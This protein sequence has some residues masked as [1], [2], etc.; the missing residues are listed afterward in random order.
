MPPN[1][2]QPTAN[3]GTPSKLDPTIVNLA[4]AIRDVE[5]KGNFSA[6]GK[7]GEY[8]AYQFTQPTWDSIAPRVL[9][10]SVPYNQADELE[11]NAVAYHYIKELKEKG[12]NAGQIASIWN[13]GKPDPNVTGTG[14]NDFGVDYDV[15]GYVNNV[16]AKYLEYKG[17]DT[18][19][20]TALP[21]YGAFFPASPD[22]SPI[23]AGFKALGNLPSAVY[24][25]GAALV[26][27][28]A[29][30][31]QTI[32]GIS[33]AGVGAYQAATGDKDK[34]DIETQ[35]F[36]AF[37]DALKQRYGSLEA[38]QNTATNDPFGFG[39]D[40]AGILAG[41]ASLAGRGAEAAQLASR[42]AQTVT[43]PV[44]RAVE[45]V[46]G[47]PFRLLGRTD[48]EA[49]GA[50]E[51]TGIRLPAGAYTSSPLVQ[52]AET[53]ALAGVGNERMVARIS[54]V[55]DQMDAL[56]RT[57]VES[58]KGADD[59]AEAGQAI[60]KGLEK[61]DAAFRKT[62]ST[63][64]DEVQK[65]AGDLAA[66]TNNTIR[67][68]DDIISRKEAIADTGN[69]KFFKDKLAVATGGKGDVEFVPV[70]VRGKATVKASAKQYDPPKFST[71]KEMRTNIGELIDTRFL[72]PFVKQHYG[73][74]KQLYGALTQDIRSTIQTTRNKELLRLYD[75]ANAKYVAGRRIITSQ[76][77]RNIARLAEQ[78]KYSNI[79]DSLVKPSMAI[80]DI[81]R[82]MAVIG[83]QGANNLRAG[84]IK[85][86]IEGARN[87]EGEFTAQGI[88]RQIKKYG[89][90]KVGAILTP[91]QF[92]GLRDLGK[93]TA[94]LD[95]VS[96]QFKGSQTAFILKNLAELGSVGSGVISILTG[97]FVL[98]MKLIG[99]VIGTEA[100]SYL[101]ASNLGQKVLLWGATRGTEFA[102]TARTMGI[103]PPPDEGTMGGY[104][105]TGTP[106]D[107]LPGGGVP[108]RGGGSPSSPGTPEGVPGV[109]SQARRTRQ[110]VGD[111]GIATIGGSRNASGTDTRTSQI[112][113]TGGGL[114]DGTAPL[115]SEFRAGTLMGRIRES[116]QNY[117]ENVRPGLVVEDITKGNQQFN[118]GL[119]S[120][121]GRIAGAMDDLVSE[122]DELVKAG[123]FEEA[124]RK[125]NDALAAGTNVLSQAFEG[126]GI[127][128]KPRGVGIGIYGKSVE[129][130]YDAV[131]VVP[132]GKED[133][134]HY[135]LADVAD[136]RF[137]QYSML[138]YR[139]APPD[140]KYGIVDEV[141]GISY[142]PHLRFNLE[143]PLTAK[144]VSEITDAAEK[145][146]IGG[147]SLR[148]GGKSID[149]IKLTKY[150]D[151]Y[152]GFLNNLDAFLASA[153]AKGIS[154][155]T[156]L[157]TAEARFVGSNPAEGHGFSSYA[158]V[159][160]AFRE[161]NPG[162]FNPEGSEVT[163]KVIERLRN[164]ESVSRQ[165]VEQ[166]VRQQDISPMERGVVLDALSDAEQGGMKKVPTK[167]LVA[168]I[169]GKSLPISMYETDSYATYGLREV[170]LGTKY[171]DDGANNAKTLVFETP[172]EHG[173]QG[174][175]NNPKHFGHTR[176]YID[177]VVDESQP[178]RKATELYEVRKVGEGKDA[179]WGIFDKKKPESAGAINPDSYKTKAAA[180]KALDEMPDARPTKKVGY[181]TELQSD[182]FQKANLET[183][184]VG[185]DKIAQAKKDAL[186][187]SGWNVREAAARKKY[188]GTD[189]PNAS[190]P[191]NEEY[192]AEMQALQRER[193]AILEDAEK[194]A[195]EGGLNPM[196][197]QLINQSKNDRYVDT[198]LRGTLQWMEKQ[199]VEEVRVATPS[200]VA[201]IEG[202][203]NSDDLAPYRLANGDRVTP[204][205]PDLDFGD[206]IE[207]LGEDYTVVSRYQGRNASGANEGEIIIAPKD[208]VRSFRLSDHIEE[209][210]S[211]QWDE[212]VVYDLKERK[213][214]RKVI[215]DE[216]D[217][218]D[219]TEAQAQKLLDSEDN[220]DMG[221][222]YLEK[223]A[224]GFSH[225]DAKE[226]LLSTF[227]EWAGDVEDLFGRGKV[228]YEDISA[229][230]G[231]DY[232]VWVV[233]DDVNVESLAQPNTYSGGLDETEITTI[234]PVPGR[235]QG[236][237]NH[238]ATEARRN[239][240]ENFGET[241]AGVLNGYVE[242]F[243]RNLQKLSREQNVPIKYVEDSHGSN[244]WYEFPLTK[245]KRYLF[246]S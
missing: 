21:T 63:L 145:A 39:A 188:E 163:S 132:R 201:K 101:F 221:R 61:F 130:N 228:Y 243:S 244:T 53:L 198:L 17:G 166:L 176:V 147:L 89:E 143:K 211:Y 72:D 178:A 64:F 175:F 125:Y 67:I 92:Q 148:E 50:S 87:A 43:R 208:K 144:Q 128:I 98:G 206:E 131:A 241:Y 74:L 78:G 224:D 135:I 22:D 177:E 82:I 1:P 60:A 73:Q 113:Q 161:E 156:E 90:D 116:L 237:I 235:S 100:A 84:F 24:G 242:L 191:L 192:N 28:L 96:K 154:G 171:A 19:Q 146:G 102:T 245:V 170:G 71:L 209:E 23:T 167:D 158:T 52:G 7:S 159:R 134:F 236:N 30:P 133:L 80:E 97:N 197:Q 204:D 112:P 120:V 240:A 42:A 6:Q 141:R 203:I 119:S 59:L 48:A 202:Y 127:K 76:F 56:A 93:L 45:G 184:I 105:N 16:Y 140:A 186:E 12:Y 26:D 129:P 8:G 157:R 75:E 150:N 85:K 225:D 33:R 155:A 66:Q 215:K 14:Q 51:R 18:K 229:G 160:N 117:L 54:Q 13:S 103:K 222:D 234:D 219:I 136:N 3:S 121:K 20:P 31:I 199:G 205:T 111:E 9:G 183:G 81:P 213:I 220:F 196:A 68:L 36:Q 172:V 62:T 174:H 122:G 210:S 193:T 91:E 79:V 190:S 181:L 94:A 55:T 29:H 180:L 104:G 88:N 2:T 38:L 200:S 232:K 37:V 86:V 239:I 214:G 226:A 49:L 124:Q 169:E 207:Y 185:Y 218:E 153:R 179:A 106:G 107:G 10:K 246:G 110:R 95:K 65:S 11:Q 25:L 231:Y 118:I 69:L 152:E 194:K 27:I 227:R 115:T 149:I 99:G 58:T 70:N 139:Y 83:E 5:S 162:F 137:H 123:K 32:E 173:S 47:A 238:E 212:R 216:S 164:K 223:R 15:P 233:D 41:G 35:T 142:E 34:E 138:T 44:G 40:L 126:S 187:S 108:P 77:A 109:Q 57:L 4:K 189:A 195:I 165:E 182:V 46:A 168:K 230:R 151:D 217:L 114:V